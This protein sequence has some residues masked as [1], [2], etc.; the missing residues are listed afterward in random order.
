MDLFAAFTD[1]PVAPS[2]ADFAAVALS[3]QRRDF[4]AKAADGSPVF[5]LHDASPATYSPA[6]ELKRVSVHFHSTCRVIVGSDCLEDQFAVIACN[7]AASELHEIFVR[8]F[9]AAVEQLPAL[10]TTTDLQRCIRGLL[11]L[12]RVL[13]QPSSR[14]VAGFWAELFVISKCRDVGKALR[15]WHANAHERFDFSWPHGCL[16]VKASIKEQRQ[17]EFALE[18]LQSPIGGRGLVASVLLQPMNGGIGV[19]D[20]ANTI[21]SSTNESQLRQKLWEN[22]AAALG[23]DFAGRIDR[24][25][26]PSYSERSLLVY[27]MEDVPSPAQP[28]DSRITGVRFVVDL[29]SVQ[30]SLVGN[31]KSLLQQLF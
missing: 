28:H 12:F 19:T 20:L 22:V 18:Q 13:D 3:I 30:S 8:C 31:P 29:S 26:D 4:L 21:E 23:S 2:T 25:F 24:R 15:A 10:A 1:L 7:A 11:D 5:L 27:A 6:I 14:E 16:E 9:A 17:H